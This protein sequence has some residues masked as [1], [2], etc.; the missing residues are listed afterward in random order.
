MLLKTIAT[1]SGGNCHIL[2]YING[3]SIILDCG[4]PKGVIRHGR[5]EM[6]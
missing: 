5:M 2:A 4:V 1:G 6:D 3:K